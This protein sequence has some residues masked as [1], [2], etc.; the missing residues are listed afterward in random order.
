M[1]DAGTKLTQFLE[2][3]EDSP[4]LLIGV[5]VVLIVS[6][7]LLFFAYKAKS[8]PKVK[9]PPG[10]ICKDKKMGNLADMGKAGSLHEY[11]IQLH[12]QYGSVVSFQFGEMLVVSLGSPKAMNSVAR[13]FDR[14]VSLFA[15]FMPMLT[16]HS[17]QYA[18]GPDGKVRHRLLSSLFRESSIEGYFESLV[19]VGH[20]G[21]ATI[22]AAE[23]PIDI[24]KL[25]LGM[26]VDGISTTL[27][28]QS[29]ESERKSILENYDFCWEEM[30]SRLIGGKIPDEKTEAKFQKSL[31][32][33]FAMI[34]E[35][36]KDNKKNN[37]M[38]LLLRLIASHEK[39][40]DELALYA[41]TLTLMVG[42]FHTTCTLMI[43][44][45]FLLT[46]NAGCQDKVRQEI[47]EVLGDREITYSDVEKMEYTHR[48]I[49]ETL[50]HKCVAPWGARVSDKDIQLEGL[51]IPAGTPVITALGVVQQNEDVWENPAKFDPERFTL[52][53]GEKMLKEFG[54]YYF[55]PFGGFGGRLCPGYRH[56]FHE[57]TIFLV[58][59][60]R[61]FKLEFASEKDANPGIVYGLVTKPK[62]K[63]HLNFAPV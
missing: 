32:D 41:E 42:G 5:T 14:P 10:P 60:L 21:V 62:E 47:K 4:Q 15:G 59:I 25:L 48:V 39:Y 27:F 26:A 6:Y 2:R 44:A 20:R 23:G 34:K 19:E 9:L 12:N 46:E 38:S 36:I 17:I 63:I 33:L 37:P 3:L 24:Y 16:K 61:N 51:E 43:W 50:R 35:K 31:E 54:N 1:A 45:M 57:A 53:K 29:S 56:T 7:I 18:N 40:D 8:T 55:S 58:H 52:E 49:K 30:E 28:G 11:L 13:V 22:R